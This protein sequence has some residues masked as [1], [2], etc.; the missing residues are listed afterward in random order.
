MK[1]LAKI[2]ETKQPVVYSCIFFIAVLMS[3]TATN[4]PFLIGNTGIDSSVFNYVA[5]VILKGGMPYRDTFDHKGPLIYLID[6]LGQFINKGLGVWFIELAFIFVIFL[7]TY[8]VAKLLGCNNVRALLVVIISML[9]FALY[10]EGGNFVEEFACLFILL[11]LYIFIQFFNG[12]EISTGQLIVSG[13]S[14]GAVCFLRINMVSLWVVMCIGVLIKCIRDKKPQM[15]IRFILWFLAGVCMITLPIVIW[16][17]AGDALKPFLEDYFS[18]NFMY[19]S[20]S[21]NGNLINIVKAIGIFIITPPVLLSLI[22]LSIVSLKG[23][24]LLDWLCLTSLL[25]SIIMQCMAG[26]YYLHYGMVFCPLVVYAFSLALTSDYILQL[27]IFKH[28]TKLILGIC[29]ALILCIIGL[30]LVGF[31]FKMIFDKITGMY[32]TQEFSEAKEIAE[33]VKE[34]SD[35]DDKIIVLGTNDLVYLLSD[36]MASS[37]YSYQLPIITIDSSKKEE[38]IE[39]MKK[40]DTELII[41]HPDSRVKA[42]IEGIVSDNYNLIDTVNEI[43]IYKKRN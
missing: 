15:L 39:E 19:S 37:K 26:Q 11:Q 35:E 25:L 41:S 18:F 29:A 3:F 12:Q 38:F 8:K 2:L 17:I 24:K 14:F 40:L 1:K 5:R 6:A 20:Y 22:F 7:L 31:S 36:R 27:K 16:L 23:K 43:A 42:V 32:R 10:Y 9:S 30:L 33:I 28:K 21:E 34:N 13:I 4:N